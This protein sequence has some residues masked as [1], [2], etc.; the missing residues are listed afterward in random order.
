[1]E[2]NIIVR[3]GSLSE[4]IESTIRQKVSKLPKF[5]DRTTGI[6]VIAELQ[7][8]E[9]TKV[10]II[11]SAEQVSD[12]VASDTG[13]NVLTAVESAIQKIETQLKKQKE[14]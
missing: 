13:S 3:N 14:K 5:Y 12:F 10:E 4:E 11:V 6:Q 9:S 2:T 1:M 7:H 8:P